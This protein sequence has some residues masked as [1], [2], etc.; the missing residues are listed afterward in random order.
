M[1]EI[2]PP[3]IGLAKTIVDH[4]DPGQC[5]DGVKERISG[6]RGK[7]LVSRFGEELERIPIREAGAGC[8]DNLISRDGETLFS[9]ITADR[10]AGDR[11][12][13]RMRFVDSSLLRR[14]AQR[15]FK[16]LLRVEETM[17]MDVSGDE[18]DDLFAARQERVAF[19]I[20][21]VCLSLEVIGRFGKHGGDFSPVGRKDQCSSGQSFL[22]RFRLGLGGGGIEKRV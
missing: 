9:I 7:N 2:K 8:Y 6:A 4:P 10:F 20:K 16:S 17:V 11:L 1:I 5:G 14:I 12:A 21:R 15:F 3:S 19:S 18:I 13:E 22:R